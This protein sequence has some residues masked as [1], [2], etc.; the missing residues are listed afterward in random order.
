MSGPRFP[1]IERCVVCEEPTGNAGAGDGSIYCDA[2]NEG[3]F[4][5]EC[6]AAHQENTGHAGELPEPAEEL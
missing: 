5:D 6:W 1:R 2:C 3:P 4:C